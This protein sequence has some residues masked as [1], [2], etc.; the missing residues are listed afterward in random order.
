V[1]DED[2]RL[3]DLPPPQRVTRYTLLV[4]PIVGR[5]RLIVRTTVATR[6]R[7]PNGCG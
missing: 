3:R 5:T 2:A 4:T 1:D 7:R 6:P